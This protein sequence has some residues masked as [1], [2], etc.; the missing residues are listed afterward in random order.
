MCDND[1][2]D[3]SDDDNNNDNND[4]NNDDNNSDN[5][6]DNNG[7]ELDEKDCARIFYVRDNWYSVT[8]SGK[9]LQL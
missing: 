3:D 5:N 1:N 4:D 6:D 7:D 9:I 2:N 8:R